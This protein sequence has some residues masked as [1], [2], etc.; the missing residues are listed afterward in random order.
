MKNH[1][2]VVTADSLEE[3]L[4]LHWETILRIDASLGMDTGYLETGNLLFAALQKEHPGCIA[5]PA[6]TA[7]I[8]EAIARN[9]AAWDYAYTPDCVVYFGNRIAEVSAE[10]AA[11]D[12]RR[13]EA[14]YGQCKVLLCEGRVFAVAPNVRKAR[15]IVCMLDFAARI[16]LAGSGTTLSQQEKDFLLHWDSEKYRVSLA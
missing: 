11:D 3:A 2:L 14:Q 4:A 13:H 15:D 9:G 7:A 1:G 10:H 16:E 12:L 8:R 6:D 5:Y